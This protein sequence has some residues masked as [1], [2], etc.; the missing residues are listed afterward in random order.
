MIVRYDPVAKELNIDPDNG[1][2][3]FII[4]APR[5]F[6][7]IYAD[8]GHLGCQVDGSDIDLRF[9]SLDEEPMAPVLWLVEPSH[10]RLTFIPKDSP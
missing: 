4:K 5:L 3:P 9:G 1:L 7:H 8:G 6:I 2:P 10:W